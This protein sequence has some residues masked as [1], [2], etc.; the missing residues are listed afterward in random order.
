MQAQEYTYDED[1]DCWVVSQPEP[2]VSR[3]VD[4]T[5]KGK[6]KLSETRDYDIR[7][8]H[9]GEHN[10]CVA[11]LNSA[12]LLLTNQ[13]ISQAMQSYFEF[14]G[15][16]RLW[17]TQLSCEMTHSGIGRVTVVMSKSI[18]GPTAPCAG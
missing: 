3:T 7:S 5:Y 17:H 11:S 1:R 2:E 13:E 8:G 4:G 9:I 18:T 10:A 16:S 6:L 15:C 12:G 14:D